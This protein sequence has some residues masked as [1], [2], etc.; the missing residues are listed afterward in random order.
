MKIN[1]IFPGEKQMTPIIFGFQK[2]F[3]NKH[4]PTR[5]CPITKSFLTHYPTVFDLAA[6]EE[7]KVLKLWQGL[8]YYSR[9]RNLHTSAQW[10]VHKNKGFPQDI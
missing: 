3:F 5:A 6:A 9:A 1:G 7:E 4:A 8:G 10:I 2:S